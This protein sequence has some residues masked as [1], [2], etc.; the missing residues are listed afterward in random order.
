LSR[1]RKIQYSQI[2]S[3]QRKIALEATVSAPKLAQIQGTD[4]E[5]RS[6]SM[7]QLRNQKAIATCASQ[8]IYEALYLEW[9][10]Q[11]SNNFVQQMPSKD[12]PTKRLTEKKELGI[13]GI[14]APYAPY[15][16]FEALQP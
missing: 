15:A 7:S 10:S 14:R 4:L 2:Y 11:R 5:A 8:K 9:S 12:S 13:M 1:Q 3:Y 16:Y 6:L